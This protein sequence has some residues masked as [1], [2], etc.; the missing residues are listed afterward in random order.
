MTSLQQD[1][2]R[3]TPDEALAALNAL[4][5]NVIGTQSASWSNMIYPFVAI[6]NAAGIKQFDP[7]PEQLRWHLDCYG[8]AGGFPGHERGEPS[9]EWREPVGRLQLV[10]EG[11]RQFLAD[12]TDKNRDV[13]E[14]RL[15]DA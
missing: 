1:A 10:V 15:P 8:G 12:P 7:S 3:L 5:S 6:L 9:T 4:R 2:P 13:M 11:V 14:A